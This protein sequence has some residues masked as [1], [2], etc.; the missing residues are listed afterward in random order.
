MFFQLLDQGRKKV[1][2]SEGDD[3]LKYKIRHVNNKTDS[4]NTSTLNELIRW[5][6]PYFFSALSADYLL[7]QNNKLSYPHNNHLRLPQ[8]TAADMLEGNLVLGS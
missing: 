6:K 5:K 8:F 4:A 7:Y 1:W 3:D 2:L